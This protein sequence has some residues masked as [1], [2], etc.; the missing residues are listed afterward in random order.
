MQ[1]LN[2][3]SKC[4]REI[5]GV[6][7]LEVNLFRIEIIVV[8]K[9]KDIF[10]KIAVWENIFDVTQLYRKI[11]AQSHM[12]K[13]HDGFPLHHVLHGIF[14]M[15][16]SSDLFAGCYYLPIHSSYNRLHAWFTVL[17][18]FLSRDMPKLLEI[19]SSFCTGVSPPF[20]SI[21]I[22]QAYINTEIK[23]RGLWGE[24]KYFCNFIT[25]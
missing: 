15:L 2:W 8:F 21:F 12:Q 16:Q 4:Q 11:W 23:K 3:K 1:L 10:K 20:L 9:L 17:C 25:F 19:W 14:G 5:D 18:L 22:L 24:V 6:V 7:Y 13:P